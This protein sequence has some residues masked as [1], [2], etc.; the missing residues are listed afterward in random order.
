MRGP[1]K[2]VLAFLGVVMLVT[3]SVVGLGILGGRAGGESDEHASGSATRHKARPP[4]AKRLA[5]VVE[6]VADAWG[7]PVPEIHVIVDPEDLEGVGSRDPGVLTV[8]ALDKDA[9]DGLMENGTATGS[10]GTPL[11]VAQDEE[12]AGVAR[13]LL[14]ADPGSF[15]AMMPDEEGEGGEDTAESPEFLDDV[16]G[17]YDPPRHTLFVA[18]DG[19]GP[20]ERIVL[21]HET[22]H[23][24]AALAAPALDSLVTPPNAVDADNAHT[25]AGEGQGVLGELL[26]ARSAGIEEKAE[27]LLDERHDEA[28]STEPFAEGG[29]ADYWYGFLWAKD[30]SDDGEE[31]GAVLAALAT[32]PPSTTAEILHPELRATGWRPVDVPAPDAVA[33]VSPSGDLGAGTYGELATALFLYSF[34]DVEFDDSFD[35]VEGWAGDRFQAVRTATGEAVVLRTAWA[36]PDRATEVVGAF[37]EACDVDPGEICETPNGFLAFAASGA[38]TLV[39]GADDLDDVRTLRSLAP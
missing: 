35:A 29:A 38:N 15:E 39:V 21:A 31:P 14:D 11:D 4:D 26:Y 37:Q 19:F 12:A 7:V 32:E 24:L 5:G 27:E 36:D 22:S 16:Y 10:A 25:A 6:E 1:R 8:V 20:V 2:V 3:G 28:E 18:F 23:A 34:P 9:F 17:H 13:R 30:V 33:A